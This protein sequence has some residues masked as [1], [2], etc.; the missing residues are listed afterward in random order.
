[1]PTF[2]DREFRLYDADADPYEEA[3]DR[4]WSALWK[5]LPNVATALQREGDVIVPEHVLA[6]IRRLPGWRSG[7]VRAVPLEEY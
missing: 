7:A 6:A 4:F 3:V 1:M 2:G 5:H